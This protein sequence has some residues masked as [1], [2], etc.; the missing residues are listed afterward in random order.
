MFEGD[1]ETFTQAVRNE[2]M[3]GPDGDLNN[4]NR[5]W[6]EMWQPI[7][8]QETSPDKESVEGLLDVMLDTHLE[9]C[10]E[11]DEER[12]EYLSE[13][14]TRWREDKEARQEAVNTIS[15]EVF[16]DVARDIGLEY[17]EHRECLVEEI[18]D[19]PSDHEKARIE[20]SLAHGM[21]IHARDEQGATM[22]HYCTRK[23][24]AELL[25]QNG[26]SPVRDYDGKYPSDYAKDA[27][28]NE[29][30]EMLKSKEPE[31]LLLNRAGIERGRQRG[32]EMSL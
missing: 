1:K 28:R 18:L 24:S 21:D 14:I 9:N 7:R 3:C 17:F 2:C 19:C 26:L 29:L 25:M 32:H 11:Q 22:L 31:Q 13:L 15:Q 10:D 6:N 12:F 8:L 16:D 30:A 4:W 27:G 5:T 20:I 23:E